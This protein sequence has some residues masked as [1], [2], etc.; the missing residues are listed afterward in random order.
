[1]KLT[2]SKPLLESLRSTLLAYQSILHDTQKRFIPIKEA[3]WEFVLAQASAGEEGCEWAAGSHKSGADI[4]FSDSKGAVRSYSCKTC[5]INQQSDMIKISSYRLTRNCHSS[6]SFVQEIDV[7]RNNFDAYCVLVRQHDKQT[8]NIAA[9]HVYLIPTDKLKAGDLD[10]ERD[11]GDW[12]GTDARVPFSMRIIKALSNQLWIHAPLEYIYPYLVLSV[13]VRDLKPICLS[14]I[15]VATTLLRDNNSY[16]L[17]PRKRTYINLNPRKTQ[18]MK[19]AANCCCPY[20]LR[21][22]RK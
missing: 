9:Y 17:R 13:D 8:G 2:F 19:K 11:R 10:W 5:C 6:A 12:I 20:N 4:H 21:S 22:R 18:N 7:N 1:M 16:H 14:S 3:Q 15:I